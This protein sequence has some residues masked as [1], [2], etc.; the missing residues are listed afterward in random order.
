V[1]VEVVTSPAVGDGL[2]ERLRTG[3]KQA[4]TEIFSTHLDAVYNYCYR[5]TGSWSVAEDLS[6]SVL[7]RVRRH[8][9]IADDLNASDA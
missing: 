3:S 7:A 6:S 2:A 4:M 5:R 1:D 8:L 9:R